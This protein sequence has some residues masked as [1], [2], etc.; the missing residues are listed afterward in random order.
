MLYCV[1]FVQGGLT[2]EVA[3][4][5]EQL[6]QAVAELA[7]GRSGGTSSV[8]G[9][10]SSLKGLSQEEKLKRIGQFEGETDDVAPAEPELPAKMGEFEG[11]LLTVLQRDGLSPGE[12]VKTSRGLSRTF[13]QR[14]RLA[15]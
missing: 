9:L 14:L 5:Y 7:G 10:I 15:R 3:Y 6:D 1:R 12:L 2:D 11:Q 8:R 4:A 13:G